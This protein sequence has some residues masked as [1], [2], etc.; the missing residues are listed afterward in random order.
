MRTRICR[1]AK[2]ITGEVIGYT[3]KVGGLKFPRETSAFYFPADKKAITATHMA[4]NDYL[5]YKM[6][7][8]QQ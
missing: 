7:E 4:L 2:T 3:V 6:E 1:K 5:N 8:K